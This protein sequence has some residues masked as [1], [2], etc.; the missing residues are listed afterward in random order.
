MDYQ[1]TTEQSVGGAT[2]KWDAAS[3]QLVSE[4]KETLSGELQNVDIELISG[5]LVVQQ[6]AEGESP[7]VVIR[8]ISKAPTEQ[9][10]KDLIAK[11][12]KF[13]LKKD[14]T[15]LQ[16]EDESEGTS[17]NVGGV[18]IGN[19]MNVFIGE[20][21]VNGQKIT[22]NEGVRISAPDKEVTLRVP[23]S[24][25][26]SYNLRNSSG[27]ILLEKGQGRADLNTSSGELRIGEFAG[28]LRIESSS[29]DLKI[30]SC[31]G[32]IN[33]SLTSG[34]AKVDSLEGSINLAATSGDITIRDAQIIGKSNRIKVTSGD[35]SLGV[36]NEKL[37]VKVAAMSGDV[38]VDRDKF[39]V[40][41]E[42]KPK[43]SSG[44]TVVS[45]GRNSVV[46]IGGSG[47]Q[48]YLEGYYGQD[49][50]D[51]PELNISAT[52]GDVDMNHR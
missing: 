23:I 6:T 7:S 39:K 49:V 8:V 24:K 13:S 41:K 36:R 19:G 12:A 4:R 17:F 37:R 18:V 32:E 14:N 42:S 45:I 27:S 34:D 2:E 52:S 44:V 26:I 51:A 46:S 16:I 33:G 30:R 22:G 48:S 25:E 29:G 28:E 47:G 9:E 35:V 1:D 43:G 40:T 11:S 10:A 21:V 15:S 31:R 3:R 5:R 38:D 20:V 50:P